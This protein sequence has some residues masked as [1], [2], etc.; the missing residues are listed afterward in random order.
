MVTVQIGHVGLGCD[1]YK[2]EGH[3]CKMTKA[4]TI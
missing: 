4:G 2:I 1:F 3:F